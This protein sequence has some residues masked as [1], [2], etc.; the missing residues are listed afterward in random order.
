[1][2]ADPMD[3]AMPRIGK[4]DLLRWVGP[5][6]L[7]MV[8]AGTALVLLYAYW[9]L[10]T[11]SGTDLVVRLCVAVVLLCCVFALQVRS[12][13]GSD[14]PGMRAI[15]VLAAAIQLVLIMFSAAY[16]SLSVDNSRAFSEHL[17]KF[18]SMYLAI[19]TLATVGFGDITP[20]TEAARV[21]VSLQMLFDLAFLGVGIRVMTGAVR[22]VRDKS[23]SGDHG[24]DPT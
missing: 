17:D 5:S 15:E 1:M 8:L 2:V 4:M 12:I 6:V 18:S 11:A 24:A 13:V 19:T 23:G 21:A 9:P 10:D 14:R 22:L 7:R 3:A 20:N 16:Y